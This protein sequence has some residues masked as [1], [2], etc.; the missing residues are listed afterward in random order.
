MAFPHIKMPTLQAEAEVVGVADAAAEAIVKAEL[1]L[2][3][4]PALPECRVRL[5]WE[6]DSGAAAQIAEQ[7]GGQ[8]SKAQLGVRDPEGM[9]SSEEPF[10]APVTGAALMT[11]PD[12]D[13][14]VR[15]PNSTRTSYWTG[16]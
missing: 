4:V 11:A 9:Y 5:L 14:R 1:G 16:I 13:R 12:S 7:E 2:E 10:W 15:L 3:G 8:V 6:T